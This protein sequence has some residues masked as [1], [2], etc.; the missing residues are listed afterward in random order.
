MQSTIACERSRVLWRQ[1]SATSP[2]AAI[3]TV[4]L[5]TPCV[6][7]KVVTNG[8]LT[9][10]NCIDPAPRPVPLWGK[11]ADRPNPNAV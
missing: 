11:R 6:V 10:R 5:W 3:L 8:L 4:V 9:P 7:S 1:I 2:S